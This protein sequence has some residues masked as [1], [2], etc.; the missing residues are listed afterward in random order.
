VVI[1]F[2]S[3]PNGHE[4]KSSSWPSCCPS[5]MPTK[6]PVTSG[7]VKIR[8]KIAW[9]ILPFIFVLYIIA[10][11]DRANVAYAKLPM[12]ADRGFSE[13][14]F[15]F[16]AGIFFVGYLLFEIPGALIV[17]R[18]SARR[19]FARI[20][21]SW[22][23]CAVI[24]GF[25]RTGPQFYAARF[26]LGVAE[27]GFFP[28]LIVYLTHWFCARDRARALSAL[29]LAI[30]VSVSIGGP[31]SALILRLDW[32]G[33][34]GWR[35]VFILEG[36]PAVLFGVVALV[37]LTDLPEEAVW[38]EP[39]ERKWIAAELEGEKQAKR[40][41]GKVSVAHALQER[42]V[43]LL[44]L[45]LF[46]ANIGTYAFIFWLP[47][48]VQRTSGRSVAFSTAFSALPFT[49]ALVS[50]VL[51]GRSSDLRIERKWHTAVPLALAG[52]FFSLSSL[53]GTSFPVVVLW[54]CAT[55]AVLFA[56]TPSFWVL[57]TLT[58]GE[59]AAAASLGL[60]NSVGNFGGF[61]GPSVVGYLLS[62]GNSH[63]VTNL[64]LSGSFVVAS[65]LILLAR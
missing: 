12:M 49:V 4:E 31:I 57:P 41:A 46:F 58:L 43:V 52:L 2:P 34:A 45:A 11:L 15:G 53:A 62:R 64:F 50:V 5:I 32:F 54:L 30:P 48:T 24:L 1:L 38:L 8:R 44:A 7:P 59:S 61:V 36:L 16:G 60:I 65:A 29:I 25:I 56:W 39:E 19:W 40:A 13:A 22:G 26:F 3:K 14:V 63:A 42:N 47:S 51:A 28:G 55:G 9:R 33:F 21:I 37:Y 18:W 20:L 6:P 17:E 10:S 35:W 27:G 23:V